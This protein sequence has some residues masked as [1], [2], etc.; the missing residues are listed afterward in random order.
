MVLA[1]KKKRKKKQTSRSMEQNRE[2]RNKPTHIYVQLIYEQRA[3]NICNGEISVSSINT[4]GKIEH[5]IW[6]NEAGE[7]SYPVHKS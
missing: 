6:K 1:K 3:N 7:L 4:V 5:P 2:A